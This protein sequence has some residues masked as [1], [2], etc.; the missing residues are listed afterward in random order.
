VLHRGQF[1]VVGVLA[2]LVPVGD[3]GVVVALVVGVAVLD[4]HLQ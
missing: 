4:R 2:G 3:G 1:G